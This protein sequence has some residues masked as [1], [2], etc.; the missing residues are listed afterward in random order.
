MSLKIDRSYLYSILNKSKILSNEL[1]RKYHLFHTS[2]SWRLFYASPKLYNIS[3]QYEHEQT[4][5]PIIYV[6]KQNSLHERTLV[7]ISI[8]DTITLVLDINKDAISEVSNE[9]NQYRSYLTL[10]IQPGILYND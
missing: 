10:Q 5:Q 4:F 7:N 3:S 6:L 2:L 8:D 9:T 1:I